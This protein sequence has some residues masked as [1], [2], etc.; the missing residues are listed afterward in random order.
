MGALALSMLLGSAINLGGC[1][2]LMH[3]GKDQSSPTLLKRCLRHFAVSWRLPSSPQRLTCNAGFGQGGTSGF[4]PPQDAVLEAISEVAKAE[5]RVA[6]T[7]NVVMG[8]TVSGRWADEWK[9]LDE[10][11][12]TYPMRRDFTAIG[13]GGDDFVQAMVGAVESVLEYPIPEG[14]VKLNL[15]SKGKYVSVRIGP[16]EVD[17]SEK[18][19]AV[20]NAMRRDVRMKYFL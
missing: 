15:S 7:T 13:T 16:V 2:S 9:I 20:Y 6:Q 11:V 8:G 12:N 18:V 1:H 10:K 14:G 19:Q 17:C 3:F 4:R 5:G